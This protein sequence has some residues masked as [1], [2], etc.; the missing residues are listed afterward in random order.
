[1]DQVSLAIPQMTGG[2]AEKIFV[3]LA[4]LLARDGRLSRIYSG[5]RDGAAAFS[6]LNCVHLDAPR[7]R[8]AVR[9][10]V[11][12]AG[13]DPARIFLLTLG[14][15]NFAPLIRL[16]LPR[17]KIVLRL[18]NTIGPEVRGLGWR[19]R[20]RYLLATQLACSSAHR[21]IVQCEY[22]KDDLLNQLWVNE[23]RISVI[24][25]FV[26]N[27]IWTHVPES[28]PQFDFPYIFVAATFK[29]QKAFDSLPA[30]ARVSSGPRP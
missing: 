5:S 14:Y 25:N 3:R 22:M 8:G 12:E 7:A 17:R 27:E 16:R 13:V 11:G 18:G 23:H 2:G 6:D 26:E 28:K 30:D 29:P 15:I 4:G 20:W 21:I 24:Y 10:F 1:M 19:A 9:R